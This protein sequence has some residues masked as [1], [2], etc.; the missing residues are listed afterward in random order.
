VL[1]RSLAGSESWLSWLDAA[2]TLHGPYHLEDD[3]GFRAG[4]A[5]GGIA[6]D[7]ASHRLLVGYATGLFACDPETLEPEDSLAG[8]YAAS[9]FM[10]TWENYA[11]VDGEVWVPEGT[12]VRRVD[13][14][15]LSLLAS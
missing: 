13:T 8:N 1:T 4:S 14:V 3:L 5:P 2:L 15:T 10:D 6:Y 12:I 11:T 9:G 7:R